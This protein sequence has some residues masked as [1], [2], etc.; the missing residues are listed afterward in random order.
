MAQE[1]PFACPESP[2]IIKGKVVGDGIKGWLP[3]VVET[4]KAAGFSAFQT[5]EGTDCLHSDVAPVSR[6]L[7]RWQS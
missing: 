7:P 3:F 5:P 6:V 2:V 1:H 4:E